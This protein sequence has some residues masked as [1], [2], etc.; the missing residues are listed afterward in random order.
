MIKFWF[1]FF[2]GLGLFFKYFRSSFIAFV[3]LTGLFLMIHVGFS[4][5]S[6]V[7]SFI[8]SVAAFDRVRVYVFS[9]ENIDVDLISSKIKNF[10][11]VKSVTKFSA[12]DTKSYIKAHSLA[13]DGIDDLS[14]D[15]FPIFLDVV[16]KDNYHNLEALKQ[17]AS[18]FLEIEGVDSVGYG[19][20]WAEKMDKAEVAMFTILTVAACL[21]AFIGV[22][23]VYQTISVVLH[24]YK[25]EIKVY[26]VVG[27]T[28]VFIVLPFIVMAVFI[29]AL[30]FIASFIFYII[31][32]R[33]FIIE[34]QNM[35]GLKFG[36]SFEYA[37]IFVVLSLFSSSFAAFISSNNFLKGSKSINE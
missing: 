37:V 12:N 32:N 28:R 14:S 11:Q 13:I 5:G 26:S 6:S 27:A 3:A 17:A 21:F 33:M 9:D 1:V 36:L 35:V 10:S 2:R 8:K 23:I 30:C 18:D 15:M 20:E 29:D 34:L 19:K 16:L 4:I 24:R 25:D 31:F 7:D 22:L